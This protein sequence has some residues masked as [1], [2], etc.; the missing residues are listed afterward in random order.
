MIEQSP[1]TGNF[2]QFLGAAYALGIQRS[3]GAISALDRA[4]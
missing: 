4:K 3:T 2:P 1:L